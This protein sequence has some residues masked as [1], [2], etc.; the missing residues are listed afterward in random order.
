MSRKQ[1]IIEG[2]DTNTGE[3]VYCF[4]WNGTPELGLHH[5][6]AA[7]EGNLPLTFPRSVAF[8]RIVFH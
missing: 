6:K 8:F 5:A 3:W 2:Y 1:C 7:I 4:D